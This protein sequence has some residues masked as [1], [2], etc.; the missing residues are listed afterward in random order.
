MSTNSA[1]Q[2]GFSSS[3]FLAGFL[4]L[5]CLLLASCGGGGGGGGGSAPVAPSI[6]TQPQNA[7][8]SDGQT[9]TF[10]VTAGGT[11]PLSYQWR[12]N[13]SD[14]AGATSASYTTPALQLADDGTEYTVVVSNTAG[15]KT[16]DVAKLT[17]NPITP[18]ITA[19][20]ANVAVAEGQAAMFSVTAS[21][22]ATLTYQWKRDSVAISGATGSSYTL[23]SATLADNGAQFT[24]TVTNG[25]GSVTSTAAILSV[26][27]N[28]PVINAQPANVTVSAGQPAMFSVTASGSA[29]IT[30]QW[31]VGGVNIVGA[32]NA[33]YTTP[34][35]SLGDSGASFTVAVTNGGGTVTSSPAILTVL[36][37]PPSITA[38]PQAQSVL[39][40]S[41]ATFSVVASGTAPL[42]Y[43]WRKNGAAIPGATAATYTATVHMADSG[44]L[45]SVAVS[46][47]SGTVVVSGDAPLTVSPA[48]P[49]ITTQPQSQ[50]VGDGAT[51]T[52]SVVATG[53]A[54]LVYQWKKNGVAIGGATSASYT[55]PVVHVADSGAVYAVSIT[56]AAASGA[57]SNNATLTV[58]A[59]APSI[60]TQP[61]S[62]SVQSGSSVTF[63]VTAAGGAPYT[64]QWRKDGTDIPGATSASYQ[65]ATVSATDAGS[66]SVVV[67]NGINPSATSSGAT[68]TVTHTLSLLAG[69]IGGAGYDDGNGAAAT[70]YNPV[71]V[72]SDAAGNLYLSDQF[73]Q[74]IRKISTTAD[75]T[76]VAG[77]PGVAGST[78]GAAASAKFN[79]SEQVAVDSDGNIY[80]A[81][82]GNHVIRLIT[83]GGTV[84]TFAGKVATT[85][86]ADGV[87][88]NARFR[89]PSG[90]AV[91]Q[92]AVP[93]PVTLVVADSGNQTIRLIDVTTA[94]VTTLAGTPGATGT[95]DDTGALARF[96]TPLGVAVDQLSGTIYVA[97][98]LNQTIRQVTQAGVVTTLAGVP[99]AAGSTDGIGSSA[100]FRTPSA[101]AID[102]AGANLYVTDR[103]NHT[104]RQVTVPGAVVT[105]LAGTALARGTA[106]GTGAAARFDTPDGIAV[107]P[108]GDVFV[109]ENINNVVRKI[110][111]ATGAVTTF[112]GNVGGR[113]FANGTGGNARFNN[114]HFV[115]SDASGTL[116]MSDHYNNVVRKIT[117]AGVVTTYASGFNAP[118]GVAVDPSG[119][120]FVADTNNNLIRKVTPG[121]AVSIF[122]GSLTGGF[123]DGTG[124]AARFNHPVA[125]ATDSSGNV[126]VGDFDNNAIRM[127]T[128]AGVVTTLAGST[129][130]LVGTADGVGTNARFNGP[131][132]LIV[133][134]STGNIFVTDRN[135]GT[136]RLI[137]MP[138]A[139]VS[140]YAGTAG[141]IGFVDG[142]GAAA[143]F[144]WPNQPGLDADGNLYVTDSNN[145]AIRK[146]TPAKVV[147]T[148]VGNQPG[149]PLAYKLVLGDLPSSID[150]PSSLAVIPGTPV[151]LAITD[152]TENS[153]LIAVLP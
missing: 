91:Y 36:A 144:N 128:P 123:L 139:D 78:N 106:D 27:A 62:Q 138:G 131:R 21:G 85:G 107:T 18:T 102:S 28:A 82:S 119:N 7:T 54:P 45:Y 80:V 79:A 46:N 44:S 8:V 77:T 109:S 30:Y 103:G 38:Q 55:T 133:E 73:N 35:T 87:G 60:A 68:L 40:G 37:I 129:T 89:S 118:Y 5:L 17:V 135:N 93:G 151:K 97:D 115:T 121:G 124:A 66:Y 143:R 6:S 142:T 39:D 105:T 2:R 126:Y 81:D 141:A 63:S 71:G 33:S 100:K 13:G 16:S 1:R 94:N 74:L 50:S 43:Q 64:Y 88:G 112:A 110:D 83:A 10:S 108:A 48:P 95:T 148:V 86:S 114:P 49:A 146:I 70:F 113:G 52:F 32:T 34:P 24:V 61:V 92:P 149:A 14:I 96:R 117:A 99:G 136:V 12:S 56:N 120:L 150:G 9:A 116:Y 41:S 127:I 25:G 58:T 19:Q 29:P 130:G 42:T 23:P 15:T 20:P 11:S 98:S 53:T 147:T 4:P 125:L 65:I 59:G 76:R 122:A 57:T 3:T 145:H 84:S 152:A 69:K 111:P 153:L 140:T 26:N 104:I 47:P 72:T 137:T 101:V 67:S 90:I 51:A 132:G 22:S 31:K 75:V 134:Q